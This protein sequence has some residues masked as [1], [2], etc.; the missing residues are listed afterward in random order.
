[1]FGLFQKMFTVDIFSSIA[2]QNAWAFPKDVP[3][4]ALPLRLFPK[5]VEIL[6][7]V[8]IIFFTPN[9]KST[10]FGKSLSGRTSFGTSF[11]KL[12]HFAW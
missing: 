2:M 10:S 5:D 9:K 3:K 1:M 8:I 6:F 11:G 12:E 4:D 7:R